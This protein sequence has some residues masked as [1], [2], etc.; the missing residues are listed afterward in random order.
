MFFPVI[1]LII[2]LESRLSFAVELS[3][4]SFHEVGTCDGLSCISRGNQNLRTTK[5]SSFTSPKDSFETLFNQRNNERQILEV[6]EAELP[7]PTDVLDK[8]FS[9]VLF[10]T[11]MNYIVPLVKVTLPMHTDQGSTVHL[12]MQVKYLCDLMINKCLTNSIT[13]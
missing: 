2:P 8:L 5:R 3:S 6:V 12:A 7:P 13:Y 1:F 9:R 10:N 4:K 11:T